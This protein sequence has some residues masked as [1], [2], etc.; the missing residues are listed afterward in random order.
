M[1]SIGDEE[2]LRCLARLEKKLGIVVYPK[3]LYG[4][5]VLDP[6]RDPSQD[7]AGPSNIKVTN[8]V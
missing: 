6:P 8:I 7:P 2:E 5:K 3:V 4:G 1:V